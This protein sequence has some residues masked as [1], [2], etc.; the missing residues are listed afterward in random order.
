MNINCKYKKPRSIYLDETL[1]PTVIKVNSSFTVHVD[2]STA[3]VEAVIGELIIVFTGSQS[4]CHRVP[5]YMNSQPRQQQG[6]R[7]GYTSTIRPY[8]Y[9]DIR[10]D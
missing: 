2:P 4:C 6:D 3:A 10:H 8:R 1:K 9:Y 5:Y 7:A